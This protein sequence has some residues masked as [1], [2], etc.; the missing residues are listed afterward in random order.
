MLILN[1]FDLIGEHCSD[2]HESEQSKGGS[3]IRELILENWD[4]NDKIVLSFKG[5]K[6][7][8]PSF[9]DESIAKLLLAHSLDELKRKLVVTDI[10]E[11][12]KIEIN[13]R[14]SFRLKQ[15]QD[16][17]NQPLHKTE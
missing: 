1:L 11:K 2:R 8:T 15:L 13:R 6:T 4:K 16:E 14:V 17:K 5:V 12:K 9:L 7:A 3:Y 10:E